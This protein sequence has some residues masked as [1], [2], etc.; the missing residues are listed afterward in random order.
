[1]IGDCEA[2]RPRLLACVTPLSPGWLTLRRD[3]CARRLRCHVTE[4][5]SFSKTD[6]TAFTAEMVAPSPYWEDAAGDTATP[7]SGWTGGVEFPLEITEGFEFGWRAIGVSVNLYNPGDVPAGLTLVIRAA[8]PV[9]NPQLLRTQSQEAIRLAITLEA[10]DE[11]V[12]GTAVNGKHVS[13][14][15]SDGTRENGMPMLDPHSDF[16]MLMPGDNLLRASAD[17]GEEAMEA[18]VTFRARYLCA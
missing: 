11:L 3:G 13:V 1:M 5:P 15:R 14:L 6:G 18:A 2:N 10:G 16:I 8:G 7:V 4:S 17:S 9:V 12:V